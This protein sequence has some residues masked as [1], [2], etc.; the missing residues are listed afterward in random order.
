MHCIPS[1]WN[2]TPCMLVSRR[3][4][5]ERLLWFCRVLPSLLQVFPCFAQRCFER[6]CAEINLLRWISDFERWSYSILRLH[7]GNFEFGRALNHGAR[8]WGRDC[9]GAWRCWAL[10]IWEVIFFGRREIRLLRESCIMSRTRGGK[11]FLPLLI[12]GSCDVIRGLPQVSLPTCLL[13]QL[14]VS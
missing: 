10:L 3:N 9:L 8:W 7:L 6:L 5:I 4:P 12:L 13:L 14:D 2:F 1:P 11:A